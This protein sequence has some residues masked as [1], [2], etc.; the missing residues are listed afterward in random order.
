VF[1]CCVSLVC[2]SYILANLP[3]DLTD[4]ETLVEVEEIVLGVDK[5]FMSL[6]G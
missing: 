6:A 3:L 2:R 4:V 1:E 5:F